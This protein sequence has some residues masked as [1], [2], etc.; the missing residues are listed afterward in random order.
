MNSVPKEPPPSISSS[1]NYPPLV[2]A[3]PDTGRNL[4][5]RVAPP[6]T[7]RSPDSDIPRTWADLVAVQARRNT[8]ARVA[9]PPITSSPD[10]DI[11]VTI[12]PS[13]NTRLWFDLEARARGDRPARVA[14]PPTISSPA[15]NV[16]AR[17][18]PP[19]TTSSSDSDIPL[20]IVPSPNTRPWFDFVEARARANMP[21]RVAPPPTTSSPARNIPVTVE[22]SRATPTRAS[23]LVGQAA[24]PP[25][26]SK[27]ARK[28]AAK[29]AR[30]A[31]QEEERQRILAS[32]AIPALLPLPAQDNVPPPGNRAGAL[33]IAPAPAPAPATLYPPPGTVYHP[34]FTG[35]AQRQSPLPQNSSNPEEISNDYSYLQ[36]RRLL[37]PQ[38]T[39]VHTGTESQGSNPLQTRLRVANNSV[40]EAEPEISGLGY[41]ASGST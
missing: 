24:P 29:R 9:P 25:N 18:A 1:S 14:P 40:A 15:S 41:N 21:A 4:P 10:S 13:P 34:R 11:P 39:P 19:P 8:P 28:K 27:S 33:P 20:T 38:Y 7:P 22:P 5:A 23:L 2:V 37:Q 17:V 12:V 16:R 30:A 35:N 32:Q 3:A 6:L 31:A 36:L 26:L